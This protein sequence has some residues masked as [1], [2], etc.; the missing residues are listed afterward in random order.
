MI[1]HT[2][3]WLTVLRGR[4]S[5]LFSVPSFAGCSDK[6]KPKVDWT[7]CTKT[8]LVL[9]NKDLSGAVLSH[10][11]L[12]KTDLMRANLQGVSLDHAVI[13]RARLQ[14][15]DL[16][17]A[18]LTMVQGIKAN[19]QE[20]NL[21][22]VRF[23]GAE[24]LRADFSNANLEKADLSGTELGRAILAGAN[25]RGAKFNFSNVARANFKGAQLQNVNLAGAYM[26]LTEIEG[27]DLSQT[28]G[29]TPQQLKLTCG[30]D[31]TQLPAGLERPISWPCEKDD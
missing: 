19:F 24:L 1:R 8:Q 15:A 7:K 6:P 17:G 22:G 21:A 12:S 5:T 9:Q 3:Q 2:R 10:A 27:V 31:S 28:I 30:D 4:L 29:I 11:N 20:A 18:N 14:E 26:Y 13:D 23:R 16:M 25:L